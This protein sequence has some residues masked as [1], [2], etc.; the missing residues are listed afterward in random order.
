[1]EQIEKFLGFLQNLGYDTSN[2]QFE[3]IVD[4]YKRVKRVVNNVIGKEEENAE[5]ID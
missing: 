2:L 1:M 5:T 4:L 3:D